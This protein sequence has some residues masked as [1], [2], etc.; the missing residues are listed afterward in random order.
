MHS[1]SIS[2][3]LE[4]GWHKTRA[5]SGLLFQI[6]LTF[7]A[8][9]VVQEIVN[10]VLSE[11]LVGGLANIALAVVGVILGAGFTRI[12]LRL[13]EG[14]TA[15]YR[16][17]IPPGRLV[18]RFFIVSVLTGMA[19]VGGLIL[20]VIPG[21]LLLVRLS[22]VRFIVVEQPPQM[23]GHFI[24]V[25]KRSWRMTHGHW[26]HLFGFFLVLAGLNIVGALLLLIGLLISVPV[27]TLAW[28]H[29]YNKLKAA[30]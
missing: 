13:A 6:L 23:R 29:V 10:R 12:I 4:F 15:L 14:H 2:E 25:L 19:V 26:W 24:E 9:Q 16:D 11:T 5:H 8:L 30:A 7:F 3:A 18:W 17:L 28:A 1:F 27:T 21:F 22:M 20:L